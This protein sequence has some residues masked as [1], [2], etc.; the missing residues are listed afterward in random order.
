MSASWYRAG[1]CVQGSFSTVIPD[2]AEITLAGLEE[3]GGS[4]P[5]HHKT[6]IVRVMYLDI[7]QVMYFHDFIPSFPPR[8]MHSTVES[9][10][11]GILCQRHGEGV[12]VASIPLPRPA[13]LWYTL[14]TSITGPPR[15]AIDP[16]LLMQQLLRLPFADP[17]TCADS[18]LAHIPFPS[19]STHHER[20]FFAKKG[21]A[22]Q[23]K[24]CSQEDWRRCDGE[25]A[26][27][28]IV[29]ASRQW[30]FEGD[31]PVAAHVAGTFEGGGWLGARV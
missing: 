15:G 25:I 3:A 1:G 24:L 13:L 2:I 14:Q 29:V 8:L 12:I 30:S 20:F 9:R 11:D 27:L 26:S 21:T 28:E 31:L 4:Q 16:S 18:P 6:D 17:R 5:T 22:S 23:Q 19:H 7:V 10:F